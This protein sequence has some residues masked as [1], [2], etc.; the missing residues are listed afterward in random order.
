MP[1]TRSQRRQQAEAER[2]SSTLVRSIESS[3]TPPARHR[4]SYQN[5][6][7][8]GR[9]GILYSVS[10]LSTPS[11]EH[12]AEG[13]SRSAFVV[14][15]PVRNFQD[16]RG[17]SYLTFQLYEPAAI[18]IHSSV[19]GYRVDCDCPDTEIV[20]KHVYVSLLLPLPDPTILMIKVSIRWVKCC[21]WQQRNVTKSLTRHGL[22]PNNGPL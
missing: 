19:D 13:L 8:E 22:V 11:I 5:H 1:L 7:L 4:G 18:R 9:T 14:G 21:V 15:R 6:P 2:L 20:C 3:G 12:A 10:E 16:S 17:G